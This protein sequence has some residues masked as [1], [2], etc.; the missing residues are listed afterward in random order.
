M[1]HL[2]VNS[3]WNPPLAFF[4]GSSPS[5]PLPTC[6]ALFFFVL[7]FFAGRFSISLDRV[8]GELSSAA[9]CRAISSS[10]LVVTMFFVGGLLGVDGG[11]ESTV[12][13]SVE[14]LT[15][16]GFSG[17][18]SGSSSISSRFRFP[19]VANLGSVRTS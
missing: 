12:G 7:I 5:S 13:G 15:V 8:R 14:W 11:L 6:A 3:F 18:D 16:K 9:S 2:N 19:L 10:L 17:L 1:T 4:F